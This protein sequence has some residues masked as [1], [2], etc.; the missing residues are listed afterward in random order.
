MIKCGSLISAGG[1]TE[2]E[3][4][5]WEPQYIMYKRVSDTSHWSIYDAMRGVVTDLDDAVVYANASS[6]ETS[7]SDS[8][9]FHATGFNVGTSWSAGT[10]IYMCI[11]RPMK[12]PSESSEVFAVDLGDNDP[13]F[14]A[15]FPI[16]M[17]LY[18]GVGAGANKMIS[19][20][21]T[22]G[23]YLLTNETDVEDS[24]GNIVFDYMDSFRSGSLATSYA[25]MWKRATGVFDCVCFSGTTP[26]QNIPHNL[27]VV[28][29]MM[30]VKNRDDVDHWYVYHKDILNSELLALNLNL[31]T[32]SNAYMWDSTTPS[33]DVFRVGFNM[34]TNKNGADYIVYLF[35]TLA[36][37]SCVG[38]YTGTNATLPVDCGFS[39]GAK[40]VLIK[41][42][43]S[44]G[45]WCFFDTTR[46]LGVGN[47][48]YLI[49]N[50]TDAEVTDDI[51]TANTSGFTLNADTDAHLNVLNAEY[52]FYAIS[53]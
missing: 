23:R 17:G 12:T 7:P 38:S 1:G 50:D 44:T 51:F 48:K 14:T 4:L 34:G 39:A 41:R 21:L 20:R 31:D 36:N 22:Q 10:Y 24:H 32:Q 40:F 26:A 42:T 33:K 8:V 52:I 19:A 18:S 28:P 3:T 6:V 35:A 53:T 13:A 45:D 43:D 9:D 47:D 2:V 15:G 27:G 30:W 25:W 5:G 49:L 11:R 37:V 46:G 16:D 29:E